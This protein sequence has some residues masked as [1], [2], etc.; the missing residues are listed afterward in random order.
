[1][2]TGTP[3]ATKRRNGRANG[4]LTALAS[5]RTR[6][7]TPRSAAPRMR[8]QM[9][10]S[11]NSPPNMETSQA[12]IRLRVFG[13]HVATGATAGP[14]QIRPYRAVQATARRPASDEPESAGRPLPLVDDGS[15]IAWMGHVVA[16]AGEDLAEP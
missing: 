10:S 14:M 1:M 4:P 15:R 3:M 11:P 12:A 2:P 9:T 5:S 6:P 16:E 13:P 7:R 8:Q